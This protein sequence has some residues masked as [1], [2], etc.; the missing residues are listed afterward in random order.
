MTSTRSM[1]PVIDTGILL[2]L[3]QGVGPVRS[4]RGPLQRRILRDFEHPG[5]LLTLDGVQL[6]TQGL[7][8]RLGQGWIGLC[9]LVLTLPLGQRPVVGEACDATRA[10]KISCLRVVRVERDAVGNQHCAASTA[11]FTPSSSFWF[12]RLREPYNRALKTVMISN[13]SFAK[14]SSK[15]VSSPWLRM[16]TST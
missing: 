6:A 1:F 15:L 3:N 12:L 4:F 10:R 14:S 5:E 9:S 16:T 7:L 2:V 13:T 8:R 11:A